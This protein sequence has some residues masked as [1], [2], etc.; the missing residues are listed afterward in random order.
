MDL[1]KVGTEPATEEDGRLFVQEKTCGDVITWAESN[2]PKLATVITAGDITISAGE[3][4]EVGRLRLAF[5][6][7]GQTGDRK[8]L[9]AVTAYAMRTHFGGRAVE[10]LDNTYSIRKADAENWAGWLETFL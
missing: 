5:D 2:C 9:L 10:G 8:R 1:F 3:D 6:I 4:G 7:A